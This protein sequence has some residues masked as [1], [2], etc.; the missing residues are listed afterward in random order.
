MTSTEEL[1]QVLATHLRDDVQPAL[2]GALAYRNRVACNLLG[3]IERELRLQPLLA[4]LDQEAAERFK[5]EGGAPL[6]QLARQLRDGGPEQ[7][8]AA[9][10]YLRRRTLA[11]LAVD[12]P[13]YSSFAEAG[14]RWPESAAWLEQ[15]TT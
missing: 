3:T 12:N 8:S 13:R 2:A 11:Q 1:L 10:A 14:A 15:E 4:A 9:V 5:L 6:P 7:E